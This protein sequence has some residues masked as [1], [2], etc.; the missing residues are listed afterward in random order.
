MSHSVSIV[1]LSTISALGSTKAETLQNYR[2]AE[3]LIRRKRFQD[4]QE[5]VG[6]LSKTSELKIE[7]VRNSNAKYKSLD[8]SVLMA[9]LAARGAIKSSDWLSDKSFG[10]NIGSSRGATELFEKSHQEFL[11][12]NKVSSLTSPTTTLGNIS[13]WVGQ[14]LLSSGP[15]F[16][17][18][19]TCSTSMHALLNGIAWIKAGLVDRF[20]VGGSE[21]PLTK[22]TIEQMKSLKIYSTLTDSSPS[23]PLDFNKSRNTMVLGEGAGMVCLENGYNSS[24]FAV[25]EGFGYG[26][27]QLTHNV[28]VTTDAKCFQASM[29]MALASIEKEEIDVIITHSPGTIKGD[30]SEFRAIKK[31]FGETI[32]SLTCNKW[33]IGHTLGAS[34]I[35]SI[36]M[37]ILMIHNQEFFK[38]PY[39]NFPQP[40]KIRKVM[41]NSVGFGGNAVS[42]IVSQA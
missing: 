32:P 22:F 2:S 29:Q 31:I 41:I 12:G 42:I 7:E 1:G 13:S 28:S 37:A 18:S 4:S 39:S 8:K 14:D 33:Q 34:G 15:T 23:R 10:I 27:E 19:I 9:I 40:E 35:I 16:S 24:A 17:H 25:I 30:Q 26:N 11:M 6:S 3:T 5:Y 21:A 36:E 38:I 20:L